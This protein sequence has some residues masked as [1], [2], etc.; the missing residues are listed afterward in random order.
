MPVKNDRYVDTCNYIITIYIC[1]ALS[2]LIC[3]YPA[4]VVLVIHTS[5]VIV[6]GEIHWNI[7]LLVDT[8]NVENVTKTETGIHHNK[9]CVCIH[10]M[11]V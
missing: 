6:M 8:L 7:L 1:L 4:D 5:P 9:Y 10:S 3:F 11:A 2:L